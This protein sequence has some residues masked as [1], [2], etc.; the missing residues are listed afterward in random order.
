MNWV[1]LS[2]T[3]T[4]AHLFLKKHTWLS[5]ERIEIEANTFAIELLLP[6]KYFYEQSNT[7]FTLGEAIE[8]YGVPKELLPLKSIDGKKFTHK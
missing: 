7:D 8:S 5:T 3:R 6:D 2:S 4:L 1:I